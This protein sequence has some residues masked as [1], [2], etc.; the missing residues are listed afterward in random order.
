MTELANEMRIGD[1]VV[2]LGNSGGGGVITSI[3]GKVVGVGPDRIEVSAE[4]IQATP[5]APSFTA[6]LVR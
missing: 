1:D 4:F 6:A 2:V 3:P 5:G